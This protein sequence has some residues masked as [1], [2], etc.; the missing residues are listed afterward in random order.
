MPAAVKA[1]LDARTDRRRQAEQIE[2][3]TERESERER[4]A[5]ST[6]VSL[7]GRHAHEELGRHFFPEVHSGSLDR[8]ETEREGERGRD[9]SWK[10]SEVHVW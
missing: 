7:T 2:R 5:L 9:R 10:S 4:D 3:E 8:I 1:R 6:Q